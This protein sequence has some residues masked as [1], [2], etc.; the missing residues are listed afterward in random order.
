MFVIVLI[1]LESVQFFYGDSKLLLVASFSTCFGMQNCP[2]S[3]PHWSVLMR[4]TTAVL[5]AVS[6][7]VIGCLTGVT[8][9]TSNLFIDKWCNYSLEVESE[10]EQAEG[11]LHMAV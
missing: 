5:M 10:T 7:N 6:L 1:H 4:Q 2:L 3:L 11:Y 9:L 8:I